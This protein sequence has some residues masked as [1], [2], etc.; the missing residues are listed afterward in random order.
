[1]MTNQKGSK[2]NHFLNRRHRGQLV[3]ARDAHH[4]LL[5]RESF[6]A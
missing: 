4:H 3:K 2:A 5:I 1:M 6:E